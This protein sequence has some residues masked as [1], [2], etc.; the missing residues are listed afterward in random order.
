MPSTSPW[1]TQPAQTTRPS[2]NAGAIAGG[3]VGGVAAI[4]FIVV[5]A[6][7]FCRHRTQDRYANTT[8]N[9]TFGVATLPSLGRSPDSADSIEKGLG[10]GKLSGGQDIT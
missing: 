2:S 10:H 3:A 5:V 8:V 9:D 1:P 7:F 4:A 6:L